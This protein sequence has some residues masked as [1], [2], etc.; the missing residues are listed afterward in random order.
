MMHD[1]I[2]FVHLIQKCAKCE[3]LFTCSEQKHHCRAC[4]KGFCTDCSSKRRP[5][6]ERG[7]GN[8]PVRVCDM[9]YDKKEP[10]KI[11]IFLSHRVNF[12][13]W[14]EIYESLV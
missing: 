1:D 5:V 13:L 4:G 11:M 9:C 7:W 12:I 2:Y 6:P 3:E 8:D 14:P 10:G